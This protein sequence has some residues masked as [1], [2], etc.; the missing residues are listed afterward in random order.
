MATLMVS[1]M[2]EDKKTLKDKIKESLD[3]LIAETFA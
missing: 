2:S 1:S 3:R